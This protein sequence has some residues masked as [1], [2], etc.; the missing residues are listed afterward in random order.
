MTPK[1][2]RFVNIYDG[3]ATQAAIK[4]GYSKKA[5]RLIGSENITKPYIARAIKEREE[6]RRCTDI[7][8]R[9]ERQAFWVKVIL[10]SSVEMKDRLRASELLARSEGDFINKIEMTAE[11]DVKMNAFSEDERRELLKLVNDKGEN[12]EKHENKEAI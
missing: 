8:T 2:Q 5:A 10:D 9:Q 7:L 4:A 6:K 12:Y 1:Q 11:M 3:N